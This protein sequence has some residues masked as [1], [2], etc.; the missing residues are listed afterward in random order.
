MDYR[1][2]ASCQRWM[3]QTRGALCVTQVYC[4]S[5]LHP[6]LKTAAEDTAHTQPMYYLTLALTVRY[7][8]VE[9][10]WQQPVWDSPSRALLL[11]ANASS[12]T[13]LLQIG[14]IL[15]SADSDSRNNNFAPT[16]A[17]LEAVD[18]P[19]YTKLLWCLIL[20]GSQ[21]LLNL[22]LVRCEHDECWI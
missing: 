10:E 3:G 9:I 2:S 1:D 17:K 11:Y 14:G 21:D 5:P 18:Y 4:N 12:T 13:V 6:R 7:K 22:Y 20:F 8:T 19:E 15:Y 16:A